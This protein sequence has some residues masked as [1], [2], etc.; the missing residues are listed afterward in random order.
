MRSASKTELWERTFTAH[1]AT[2]AE[3]QADTT[4]HGWET[5][6]QETSALIAMLA[7]VPARLPEALERTLVELVVE[8]MWQP[9]GT[10]ECA[11]L[12]RHL[13]R[14]PDALV[15][16]LAREVGR[17]WTALPSDHHRLR[18]MILFGAW[19]D[20]IARPITKLLAQPDA[21]A[22]FRARAHA[23]SLL[24]GF[25]SAPSAKNRTSFAELVRDDALMADLVRALG[26]L[27]PSFGDSDWAIE[28]GLAFVLAV[29][30][31]PKIDR[32]LARLLRR[33]G[34][35]SFA[36]ERVLGL[37]ALREILRAARAS[38]ALMRTADELAERDV[39]ARGSVRLLRELGGDLGAAALRGTQLFVAFRSVDGGWQ[40][41][42]RVEPLATEVDAS[43][44]EDWGLELYRNRDGLFTPVDASGGL[45]AKV[46]WPADP[47]ELPRFLEALGR[48][49]G[50]SF[51]VDEVRQRGLRIARKNID[52]WLGSSVVSLPA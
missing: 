2:R 19:K 12:Y 44:T 23:M 49:E 26:E 25:P 36:S 27:E 13:A 17:R 24:V 39:E 47:G 40:G 18:A 51:V 32:A 38:D 11:T 16:P 1:V 6:E 22:R 9:S 42:L 31:D 10:P 34:G 28:R 4:G 29:A 7:T 21:A 41:G 5:V 43:S 14:L 33:Y 15:A 20:P 8:W 3:A 50:R 46:S 48:A 35:S 30:N 45:P 52:R 37:D